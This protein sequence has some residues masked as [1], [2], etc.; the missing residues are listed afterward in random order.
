[1]KAISLWQPWATLWVLGWKRHETRHW[2]THYRGPLV[3]HAAKRR[4][5][6]QDDSLSFIAEF[7][8]KN[9]KSLEEI[10][11]AL[12]CGSDF[13]VKN[14]ALGSAVGVVNMCMCWDIHQGFTKE[15]TDTELIMGNWEPGRFAW[16]ADKP[17][18]F[19]TPVPFKGQQ[20]FFE[21]PKSILPEVPW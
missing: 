8:S 4:G 15:Q 16:Q 18:A 5:G 14:M 21:I 13:K 2:H 19:E 11:D 6:D 20:G 17:H 3:V 9:G 10:R 12:D 7:L 1:M